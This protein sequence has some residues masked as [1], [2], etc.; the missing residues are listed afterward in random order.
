MVEHNG[1]IVYLQHAM[2]RN[3]VFGLLKTFNYKATRTVL[4]LAQ[5]LVVMI[6]VIASN[7]YTS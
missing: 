6:D 7:E 1:E 5:N 4:L 2:I 3:N